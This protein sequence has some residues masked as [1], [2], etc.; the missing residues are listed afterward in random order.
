MM[1]PIMNNAMTIMCTVT[2]RI[3]ST[4]TFGKSC[5]AVNP[6]S[7]ADAARRLAPQRHSDP[8]SKS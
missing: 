8:V 7:V 2:G 5:N 1:T 3:G 6:R 4:F